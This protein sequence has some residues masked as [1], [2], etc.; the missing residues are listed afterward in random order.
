MDKKQEKFL[1]K[2]QQSELDAVVMYKKLASKYPEYAEKFTSLAADEGRHASVLKEITGKTLRP[3]NT[4]GNF[5]SCMF[6]LVGKKF[7]FKQIA[8]FEY[9]AY[10]TYAPLIEEYPTMVSVR[11]DEKRHGDINMSMLEEEKNKKKAKQ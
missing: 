7:M 8:G 1:I 6:S 2:S 11:E 3:K 10:D 4:L 9:K 5:V